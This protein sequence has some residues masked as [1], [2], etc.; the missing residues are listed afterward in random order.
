[1]NLESYDYITLVP[2]TGDIQKD[3]ETLMQQNGKPKTFEHMLSVAEVSVSLAKRFKLNEEKCRL[4]AVL[5]DVS[6]VMRPSDMLKYVK[7]C[8]QAV[9][10]AEE[11][12]PFLLH[13]R[14]SRNIAESYFSVIDLDVLSAVECH[15]TLKR[16]ASP[17]D[18]ILFIADKLAWDQEG[19]PPFCDA[20]HA[21][22]DISLEKA[23]YV[24][25]EYMEESGKLLCP[26]TNWIAAKNWL[27]S[28]I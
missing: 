8:G 9:C 12:F 13:Q 16:E 11:R 6:A 15:T 2:F 22:L 14:L 27:Q 4:A 3:A 24:Y 10:E 19:T 5:H 26:H 17:Y 18:M 20:V 28:N 23:C 21:A 1:M 7:A 25:M